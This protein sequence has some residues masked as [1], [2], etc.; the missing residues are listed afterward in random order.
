MVNITSTV[1]GAGGTLLAT[2]NDAVLSAGY[3]SITDNGSATNFP[4]MNFVD[5]TSIGDGLLS[6]LVETPQQY[7]I[8]PTNAASTQ[9]GFTITQFVPALGRIVTRLITTVTPSA[10]STATTICNAFRTQVNN[11]DD[12]QVVGTG[13]ATLILTADSGSPIFSVA[14]QGVGTLT[15]ASNMPWTEAAANNNVSLDINGSAVSLFPNVCTMASVAPLVTVTSN[16]HGLVTGMTVVLSGSWGGGTTLNGIAASATASITTRI[17]RL[18][19]NTFTLDDVVANNNALAIGTAR[20]T[21]LAQQSKGTYAD[22]VAAGATGA[23]AGQTYTTLVVNYDANPNTDN[24]GLSQKTVNQATLYIN[25][26]ATNEAALITWLDELFS[27][28]EKGATTA[29]PAA[30]AKH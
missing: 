1:I 9:F 26:G 21:V 23:V 3:L 10:G 11:Y 28:Y 27:A 7:I 25:E 17:T 18:G 14:N 29:N 15:I 30:I 24:N 16:G 20:I 4:T 13:T 6:S 22:L 5:I 2:G 8:T 19:V 12:I